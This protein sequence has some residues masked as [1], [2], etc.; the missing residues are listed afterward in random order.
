MYLS[1]DV[2]CL[3]GIGNYKRSL[4]N[5]LGVF[6]IEQLLRYY[7]KKY[8]DLTEFSDIRTSGVGQRVTLKV[9]VLERASLF[10]A[11]NG[12][13]ILTLKVISG[14]IEL[15]LVWY[16]KEYWIDRFHKGETFVISGKLAR[17][18][19]K[20]QISSPIIEDE[21]KQNKIGSIVGTYSLT[22]GITNDAVRF[23]IKEA[24]SLSSEIPEI[25]S[26]DLRKK[27]TLLPIGEA[28]R[29]IHFPKNS[30]ELQR[31]ILR[32]KTDELLSY[33]LALEL[34]KK[35]GTEKRGRAFSDSKEAFSIIKRLDFKL[36]KA[37]E[38]AVKEIFSDLSSGRAMHRLLQGDV[39]SGK[40]VVAFLA[41]IY[42]ALSG[43]QSVLL[44]P[45]GVLALQHSENFKKLLAK[46]DL[47]ISFDLLK[48]STK[49]KEKELIK[50][51]L[52]S[53]ELMC[54]IGTHAI[55]EEDVV[56]KDLG[57]IVTDEQHRFGVSQ[58]AL[59]EN[60]AENPNILVMSATPIP[61][62]LTLTV[63]GDL[64]ISTIDELPIGRRPIKT[65]VIPLSFE[66]RLFEFLKTQLQEGRQV[67]LV[68]PMIEESGYLVESSEEIYSRA[69]EKLSDFKVGLLHGK[70]KSE[71]KDEV[72]FSFMKGDIDVLC[73]TTV[74]EVGVNVPNAT[75]MA[76]Y[77]AERFG[78]SQLH[79][80]RGRVG[81]GGLQSY[82]F[83]ISDLS[84]DRL[85]MM[86][87]SNDGF[88]IAEKDLELRGA[89]D[90]LGTKQ[91]GFTSFNLAD[92]YKDFRL[93]QRVLVLARGILD[94][95]PSLSS[96]E[97]SGLKFLAE[98]FLKRLRA[99]EV[100]AN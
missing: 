74:I 4:F 12:L 50:K 56:F 24:I 86:E 18:G 98:A 3:R 80:L 48:G 78:L 1:D 76:I 33:A 8:T 71:E 82:C 53:G 95:D 92:V 60:K 15:E 19:K 75:V 5:K 70:M 55:L 58:R 51:R 94:K 93:F 23:A 88:E 46:L 27:T 57:L 13:T 16:R 2:S 11:A 72:L 7:P 84:N 43:T 100:S 37:Q 29:A 87:R 63:F 20:F 39:G 96:E 49:I 40:T 52:K 91:S 41:M 67:Y 65:T 28:I 85:K 6:S 9:E 64:D 97:N 79:Q 73:S 38:K 69:S 42:A 89:G 83:L 68:V 35:E 26:S 34:I 54:L 66:S 25:L 30:E 90:L 81:R 99:G 44:A 17:K 22:A 77:N 45:T 10:F 59:L 36:T 31:A 21:K 32:I 47:D 62:T 14:G 61:R